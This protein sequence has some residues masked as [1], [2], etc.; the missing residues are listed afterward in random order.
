MLRLAVSIANLHYCCIGDAYDVNIDPCQRERFSVFFQ[1]LI[2]V[3]CTNPARLEGHRWP[4][5]EIC[6]TIG[7]IEQPV[8]R[9]KKTG[10]HAGDAGGAKAKSQEENNNKAAVHSNE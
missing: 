5:T 4:I 2:R 3:P 7:T 6:G 8:H 10:I 1:I 9:Y